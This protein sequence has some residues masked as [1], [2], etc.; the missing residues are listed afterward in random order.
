MH[1]IESGVV[2]ADVLISNNRIVLAEKMHPLSR[3][4]RIDADLGG[5]F[6]SEVGNVSDEFSIDE[7][8]KDIEEEVVDGK[9]SRSGSLRFFSQLILQCLHYGEV[10]SEGV[11]LVSFGY[12]FEEEGGERVGQEL[13]IVLF[14]EAENDVVLGGDTTISSSFP[15]KSG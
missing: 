14:S 13:I 4:V 10:T 12:G 6:G 9:H 1:L 2:S 3:I 8:E 5:E 7:T 15:G 11:S